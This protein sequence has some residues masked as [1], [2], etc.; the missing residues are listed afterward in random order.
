MGRLPGVHRSLNLLSSTRNKQKHKDTRARTP[1][2][3]IEDIGKGEPWGEGGAL[4][5]YNP[6]HGILHVRVKRES[7]SP[8]HPLLGPQ[9]PAPQKETN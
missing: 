1:S 2:V 4:G 9:C 8:S 6:S 3:A 5:L 7:P